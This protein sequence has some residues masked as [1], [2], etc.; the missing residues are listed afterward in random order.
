MDIRVN[1]PVKQVWDIVQYNLEQW[2][3][4]LV[5]TQAQ[6]KTPF[7]N[8]DQQKFTNKEARNIIS[9]GRSQNNINLLKR[10]EILERVNKKLRDNQLNEVN[11]KVISWRIPKAIRSATGQF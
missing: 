3:R 2:Q 9:L 7:F 1:A 5:S 4:F 11:Q 8:K 6:A 10:E